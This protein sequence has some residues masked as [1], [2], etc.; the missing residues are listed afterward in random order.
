LRLKAC[1]REQTAERDASRA[2]K[3]SEGSLRREKAKAKE[4]AALEKAK[5]KEA[6]LL[7]KQKEGAQGQLK[8]QRRSSS[9]CASRSVAPDRNGADAHAA[10][11]RGRPGPRTRRLAALA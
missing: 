11:A 3:P 6:A 7:A 8:L 5:A 1:Q 4:L 9:K 10:A 2:K